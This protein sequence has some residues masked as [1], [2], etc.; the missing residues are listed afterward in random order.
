[1]GYNN[2]NAYKINIIETDETLYVSI[3]E[4]YLLIDQYLSSSK[5][6]TLEKTEK[7]SFNISEYTI[8]G[9]SPINFPPEASYNYSIDNLTVFLDAVY[10]LF[11]FINWNG[12]SQ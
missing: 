10:Y 7:K 2:N 3:N 5:I 9:Y 6:I 11:S 8:T 1:M 4:P 12:K